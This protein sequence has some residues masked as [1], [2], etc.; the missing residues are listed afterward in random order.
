VDPIALHPQY[1]NLK[2]LTSA[3]DIS[4]EKLMILLAREG[5]KSSDQGK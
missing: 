2:K 4:R 1:T 3:V 5:A